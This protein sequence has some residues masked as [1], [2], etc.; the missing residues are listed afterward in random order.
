MNKE[1]KAQIVKD[2]IAEWD[3]EKSFYLDNKSK[4]VMDALQ[5]KIVSRNVIGFW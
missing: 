1:E 5:E 3:L 2:K 4:G